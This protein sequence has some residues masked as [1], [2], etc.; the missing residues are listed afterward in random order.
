MGG[1]WNP[2]R[3]RRHMRRRNQHSRTLCGRLSSKVFV[4]C[5]NYPYPKNRSNCVMCGMVQMANMRRVFDAIWKK[6]DRGE[7]VSMPTVNGLRR[8]GE[9]HHPKQ[10]KPATK[11]AACKVIELRRP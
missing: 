3:K 10:R 1:K 5:E 8:A 2:R 4:V 6:Y 11:R 9:F 7:L